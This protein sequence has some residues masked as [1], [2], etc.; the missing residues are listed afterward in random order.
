MKKREFQKKATA[1]LFCRL[2]EVCGET[3]ENPN[4]A[5]VS[6]FHSTYFKLRKN[7]NLIK[8]S[9]RQTGRLSYQ[10]LDML[11]NTGGEKVY[12]QYQEEDDFEQIIEK[13]VSDLG[14]LYR[15]FLVSGTLH[16]FDSIN[17]SYGLDAGKELKWSC[18]KKK[19]LSHTL[20]TVLI[21]LALTLES[22]KAFC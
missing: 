9:V 21:F 13:F 20:T 15:D 17:L 7:G 12:Y 4:I 19:R 22:L 5:V 2:A 18:Q 1:E 10:L 6:K 16:G 14:R 8:I 3:G 11:E